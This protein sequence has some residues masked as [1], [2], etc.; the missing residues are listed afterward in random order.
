MLTV[1]R[2]GG[3]P[4]RAPEPSCSRSALRSLRRRC[5]LAA[6]ASCDAGSRDK[7]P[8]LARLCRSRSARAARRAS[9]AACSPASQVRFQASSARHAAGRCCRKARQRQQRTFA[10]LALR[11]GGE[12][13]SPR[14][15]LIGKY[16]LTCSRGDSRVE[17]RTTALGHGHTRTGGASAGRSSRRADD[18]SLPRHESIFSIQDRLRLRPASANGRAA[19]P[20]RARQAATRPI[21]HDAGATRAAAGAGAKPAG[22]QP[23][24]PRPSLGAGRRAG[25]GA[26]E[27]ETV[28]VAMAATHGDGVDVHQVGMESI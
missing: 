9:S 21:S 10:R 4:R 23:S 12:G 18:R 19:G 16:G 1:S 13:Q 24:E 27:T 2:T 20:R 8:R 28:E 7:E 5:A 14:T 22:G 3:V 6:L 25:D 11:G 15:I 17:A 26:R